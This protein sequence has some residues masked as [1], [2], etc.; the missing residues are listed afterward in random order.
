MKLN[1]QVSESSFKGMA[2]LAIQS[3]MTHHETES[4]TKPAVSQ[5]AKT[6]SNFAAVNDP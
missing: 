6:A 1:C 3:L 5:P 2:I 4:C